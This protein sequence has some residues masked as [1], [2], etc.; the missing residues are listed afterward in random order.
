[1]IDIEQYIRLP[2]NE[3]QAHLKLEENCIVRGGPK[4][5]GLSSYCK[6]LMA[7]I[8]DTTIP[9][10][11]K[12]HICHACHNKHCSNPKHLYWGTAKENAIDNYNNGAKTARERTIEKYGIEKANEIFKL[13]STL[14]AAKGGRKGK[15]KPKSDHHRLALSN[16]G[17][18]TVW[19]N[20]GFKNLKIKIGGQI[21]EGFVQG[22]IKK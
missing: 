3:R 16:A 20:N 17:K 15:G 1:M 22:M 7:H 4:D 18:G 6:G 9:S 12:I 10:G 5:G 13:N 8:L 21:P 14:A 2:L 11:M 19:F